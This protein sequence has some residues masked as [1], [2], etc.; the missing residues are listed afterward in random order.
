MIRLLASLSPLLAGCQQLSDPP[1]PAYSS[2]LQG[3]APAA[4][5]DLGTLTYRAVDLML[6]A[7]PALTPS[8]PLMVATVSDVQELDTS[9]PF[10]NIVADFVRGRLV[11]NGLSVSD[12]RLRS[13]VLLSQHQGE[14]MLSRNRKALLPPPNIAAVVTGTYA[15]ADTQVFVS[16]KI[17]SESDSRIISAADFVVARH[18]G[19]D[20]LLHQPGSRL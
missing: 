7:A 8:T 13:A 17:V 19:S 10:G 15:V 6:A 3:S 4:H 20:A 2:V 12:I 9:T 5:R 1:G 11:Q 18:S 16:L 14:L